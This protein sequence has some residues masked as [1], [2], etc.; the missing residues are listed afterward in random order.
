MGPP[1][2]GEDG[3]TGVLCPGPHLARGHR[4]GPSY[5]IKRS[6]Y[7]NRTVTFIQQSK[8]FSR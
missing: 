1:M 7:S 6:K 8:I 3:E 4:W 2:K 5:I